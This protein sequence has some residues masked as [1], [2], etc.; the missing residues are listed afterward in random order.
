MCANDAREGGAP[1]APAQVPWAGR[2]AYVSE[3]TEP[4][5]DVASL[6]GHFYARV[7]KE[8]LAAGEPEFAADVAALAKVE[9]QLAAMTGEPGSGDPAAMR[10]RSARKMDLNAR[11]AE[12]MARLSQDPAWRVIWERDA[13]SA[14][15]LAA[16]LREKPGTGEPGDTA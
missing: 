11:R 10:E 15:R 5:A 8:A 9:N 2:I 12:I 16:S 6:T 4:G 3:E 7:R 1:K 14:R 13:E